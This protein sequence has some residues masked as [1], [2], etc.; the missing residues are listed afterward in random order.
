M[1]KHFGAKAKRQFHN[2]NNQAQT[3]TAGEMMK[4]G[5]SI[6][7]TTIKMIMQKKKY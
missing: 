6:L 7:K 3:V 5:F 1:V 4:Q 2:V